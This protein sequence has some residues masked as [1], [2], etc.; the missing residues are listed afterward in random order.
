[1]ASSENVHGDFVGI[2]LGSEHFFVD[3][4][5]RGISIAFTEVFASKSNFIKIT[6]RCEL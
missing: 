6:K 2:K 5:K 3:V 1:V 4:E